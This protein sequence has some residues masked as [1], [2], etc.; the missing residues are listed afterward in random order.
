[1]SVTA[2]YRAVDV[3]APPDDTLAEDVD[4]YVSIARVVLLTVD[5]PISSLLLCN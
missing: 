2:W 5:K 3:G 4:L 1:M